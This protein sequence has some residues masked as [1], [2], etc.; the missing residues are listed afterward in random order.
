[1]LRG[2]A[3]ASVLEMAAEQG[4]RSQDQPD[5]EGNC[6]ADN[7]IIDEFASH[8]YWCYRSRQLEEPSGESRINVRCGPGNYSHAV[9]SMYVDKKL[10]NFIKRLAKHLPPLRRLIE[11]RDR[12][13][14]EKE[15]L[16]AKLDEHALF[17]PN[18]HFYSPIPSIAEIRQNEEKIFSTPS[19]TLPGVDLNQ[20]HQLHLLRVFTKYYKELPFTE[21]KIDGLRYFYENPAYS[22]SDAI[23][24][25]CMIRHVKPKKIV[26]IGSGYSSCVFLD[27]NER[28]FSNSIQCTFVEPYPE[29]LRSLLKEDDL[30]RIN[31][32]SKRIQDVELSVFESLI[33][34]DILFIDSTHV[35]KVGSDVNRI[36]FE[37]LPA[38]ASGV[39]VH[40]HDI[41]YPFEYP[42][43][44]I[45]EGR[46]WN[47]IYILH[48]FLQYN[49]SF[50]IT[51]FNTFL[52]HF[53]EDYFITNMPLC[54]RNP[55]GSL[56]LRKR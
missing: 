32:F 44:W 7:R 38:L 42:K 9:F 3:Y 27:T 5:E 24:L 25:Y 49:S 45:Y 8:H 12:L 11:Q 1:M 28:F 16:E 26:E 43:E 29:L 19:D 52:E 40:F 51:C 39:Y 54:L 20:E 2:Q 53:F 4:F 6:H 46:A 15:M 48:A 37:I 41:F 18:G 17:V 50:E 14:R 36:F 30:R 21:Q 31:I 23:I 22:Y 56:W 10:R 35:S 34:N 33:E 47:E 13:L 55:G